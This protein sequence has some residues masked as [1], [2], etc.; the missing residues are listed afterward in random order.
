MAAL[1]SNE[2]SP[3]EGGASF[4]WLLW[5]TAAMF[6][7]SMLAAYVPLALKLSPSKMRIM[8]IF[9]CGLLVGVALI[10]IIPEGVSVIMTAGDG[11]HHDTDHA[12][13][14]GPPTAVSADG[15]EEDHHDDE[16][17]SATLIGASLA[18]GFIL[19][20]V[21]DQLSSSHMGHSHAHLPTKRNGGNYHPLAA[22]EVPGE[23][24]LQLPETSEVER[25]HAKNH[26]EDHDHKRDSSFGAFIGRG[27]PLFC[28]EN[29]TRIALPCYFPSV[30]LTFIH[31]TSSLPI[32]ALDLC[33]RPALPWFRALLGASVCLL[34]VRTLALIVKKLL[35]LTGLLVHAAADGVALGASSLSDSSSLGAV[36]FFAGA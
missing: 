13:L 3:G 35:S 7:G 22:N 12:P 17:S 1:G 8:S 11:R 15:E 31:S 30:S 25:G 18:A 33:S 36:V 4:S 21:V 28:T 20:L 29:Q 9:G 6:V 32:L 24:A 26:E 23:V 16:D 2:A 27:L 10:V 34:S 14:N 19:Q 5:L